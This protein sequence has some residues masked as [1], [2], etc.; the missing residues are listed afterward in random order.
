MVLE[1]E[2]EISSKPTS[3]SVITDCCTSSVLAIRNQ[4][5][6]LSFTEIE[7]LNIISWTEISILNQNGNDLKS[8]KKR[9]IFKILESDKIDSNLFRLQS[10]RSTEIFL[11]SKETDEL[12]AKYGKKTALTFTLEGQ[13]FSAVFATS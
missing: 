12:L 5:G 1:A 8:K 13:L 2:T 9:K 11:N 6:W 3:A 4:P 10:F 7:N